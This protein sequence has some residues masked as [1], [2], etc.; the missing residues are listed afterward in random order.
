MARRAL[1]IRSVSLALVKITY[2]HN[3]GTDTQWRTKEK[4]IRETT[5]C[6]CMHQAR[7]CALRGNFDELNEF[8][9][10]NWNCIAPSHQWMAD[11]VS[12]KM[13]CISHLGWNR[14]LLFIYFFKYIELTKQLQFRLALRHACKEKHKLS[15]KNSFRSFGLSVSV[16]RIRIVYN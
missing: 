13:K 2:R 4:K 12:G 11:A 14:W 3:N 6:L 1:R 9:K 7:M 16:L 15:A 5:S 8:R 10:L